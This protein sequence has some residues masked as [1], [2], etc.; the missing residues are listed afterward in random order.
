MAGLAGVTGEIDRER[1]HEGGRERG[2]EGADKLAH[3][4]GVFRT[5]L[6]SHAAGRHGRHCVAQDAVWRAFDRDDIHEA[7]RRRLRRR[8][9]DLVRISEQAGSRRR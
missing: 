4:G 1:S 6:L 3:L 9:G 5:D 7:D 2:A 8:I